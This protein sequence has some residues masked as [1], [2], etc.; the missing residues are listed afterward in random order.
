MPP[1]SPSSPSSMR[2]ICSAACTFTPP[3]AAAGPSSALATGASA[4]S[5]GRSACPP[6]QPC[7]GGATIPSG[8]WGSRWPPWSSPTPILR[9][10]RS[11]PCTRPPCG[12]RCG[13]R[14]SPGQQP[15]SAG[16]RA[17]RPSAV[18]ALRVVAARPGRDP[19]SAAG[20]GAALRWRSPGVDRGERFAGLRAVP[21]ERPG[22][23][24]RAVRAGRHR[25]VGRLDHRDD[26]L[27]GRR[28]AVPVVRS[29]HWSRRRRPALNRRRFFAGFPEVAM[30]LGV[31]RRTTGN[32]TPRRHRHGEPSSTM[33][34][35]GRCSVARKRANDHELRRWKH[36]GRLC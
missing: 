20:G 29:A 12:C 17:S 35:T 26:D 24:L 8:C 13:R 19:P 14:C 2:G 34:L 7:G 18:R 36:D 6:W 5:S 33:L 16:S 28:A 10:S 27:P 23:R 30:S 4:R 11:W 1:W 21:A 9:C 22:R 31:P 3:G 32:C 15:R 25:G